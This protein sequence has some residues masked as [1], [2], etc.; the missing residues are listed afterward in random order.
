[1]VVPGKQM[2]QNLQKM[3][4]PKKKPFKKAVLVSTPWP[5]YNRPSIQLG[6]LKSY[7]KTQF[8]DLKVDSHHVY[9]K[10]A[11]EIGY[12]LYRIIS[13]R[14]WLA[15]TVYGA[16]LYPQRLKTV[17]K[18]F[19]RQAA[20]LSKLR[21]VDFEKLIAKVE[22]VSKSFISNV[23]WAEYSFAGFSICLCQLTS[24]LYFIRKIKR[25]CPN[26]I[27]VV[28]GSMFAGES[29]RGLFE[30]FPE[31]NFVVNGEGEIP[32]SRL[33]H[34]LMNTGSTADVPHIA[35]VVTPQT[36]KNNEPILFDQLP[37]S[38]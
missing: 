24:S 10:V 9:L 17:N 4:P 11:A 27:I 12:P 29:I 26:L 14:T 3:L 22:A 28:G 19:Q 23:K 33:V 21:K 15:E 16:L 35:G 1:M 8:P 6:S 13:E 31:I 25:K 20:G 38:F 7:L 18:L 36:A 5:L 37:F 34:H 32:L 2:G 30:V